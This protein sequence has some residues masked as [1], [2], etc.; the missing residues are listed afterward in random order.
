MK[1]YILIL[2]LLAIGAL[3]EDHSLIFDKLSIHTYKREAT[4]QRKVEEQVEKERN[5]FEES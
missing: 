1:V 4:S 3:A 2:A 5:M